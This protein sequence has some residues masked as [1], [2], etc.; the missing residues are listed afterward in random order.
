MS[1]EGSTP[2]RGPGGVRTRP[3]ALTLVIRLAFG[4]ALLLTALTYPV[5]RA[6]AVFGNGIIEPGELCD[7]GN[8]VSGDGCTS[9]G[10]IEGQCYDPG[11]TFSFFMFSDSY[12][13]AGS[14][15]LTRLLLDAVNRTRYPN[16]VIPRFWISTG[17]IPFMDTSQTRLDQLNNA[18]SDANYPF[19]CAAGSRRFPYFVALGNHDVDGYIHLT[20]QLQYDYW[21]NFLGPRLPTALLGVQN[22][23]WG[24]SVG[25]DARTTYSFDYKNAHFVV[26][27]QYSGD[28]AYPTPNPNA[29][30]RQEMMTWIDQDLAATDRP[31]KFVFGHEPAWSYCSNRPG[32]GGSQCPVGHPDNL[33]PPYRPRPYSTTGPWTQPY[34]RHWQD[35]L[36]SSV[37]PAGSRDEFWRMLGRHQVVAH[38]TGHVHT[39]SGRLVRADGTRRNEIHAFDKQNLSFTTADGIWEIST[40]QTHTS[41]GTLYTLVTVQD[42]V[43]TF[44]SYDQIT[45]QTMEPFQ[46]IERWSVTVGSPPEVAITSPTTGTTLVSPSSVSIAAEASDADGTVTEVTFRANGQTIGTDSAPP[47][48]IEWQNPALGTYALT[49]VATDNTGV[50]TTSPAVTLNI[51][52]GNNAPT[53]Q[54]IPPQS[55]PEDSPFTLTASASDVDPGDTLTYSLIDGPPGATVNASSGEFNWTPSEADGPGV[56]AVRIGVVDSAMASAETEI[57][58]TVTEVNT[59]P[60]IAPIAAQ[61]VNTGTLLTVAASATD[62]D[63]PA[64]TLTYSLLEPVGGATIDANTGIFTWIPGPADVGDHQVTIRVSDGGGASAETTFDVTVTESNSPPSL[65]TVPP[66]SVAEGTLLSLTVSAT[67]PDLPEDTLT[68]NLVSA[69]PGAAIVPAS[70]VFS[71][72][73]G[74]SDGPGSHPVTVRVTDAGGATAETTFTITVTETNVAPVVEAIGPVTVSEGTLFSHTV[75][76]T[77]ADLPAQALT[78]SIVTAPAGSILVETTGVFSWTP[79]E[80]D[81]PGTHPVT[82]RVTDTAGASADVGFSITVTEANDPPTLGPIEPQSVNEGTPLTLTASATDSDVPA[83]TLTYSLVTAPMGA[84]IGATTGVF[85]WTPGEADGPDTH[86][87]TIR[88]TDSGGATADTSFTIT[89]TES[90]SP[91]SLAA[92]GAQT[93]SEGT[94]LTVTASATDPDLP[95][96]TLTYSLVTAPAGAAIGASTGVFTWTP[97][98]ADAPGTHGVTIR[99]TDGSGATA[100]TSFTITATET[101]TAPVLASIGNQPASEGAL[102]TVTASATDADSPAQT[103]TYSIVSGPMGASIAAD[104]GVFSWTPDEDDGPAAHQVT[105]RVSDGAGGTDE[106]TFTIDVSEGNTAPVLAAIGNQSVAEGT[107]LTVT[108]SATD[109]DQPPQALTYSIAAAPMGATINA[110]TGAFSWTPGEADGPGAHPVTIRVTDS[111]GASAETS[112]TVTVT[113]VNVAPVLTSIGNQSVNEGTALNLTASATDADVPA[114]TLTYSL[115]TAPLGATINATTG[116]F[117]WTPDE[118]DGGPHPVTIRV[119]DTAGASAE[120]SFTITVTEGNTPPVLGPIAN[121]SAAEGT[122]VS[123]NASATDADV[124]AQTLTYSL[125]TAPMGATIVATTGAF[126]WTPGEADGPGTHPVT[127]RVTDSGGAADETSFTI[128]VSEVNTAP[129]L[130]P[131]GNQSVAEGAPLNVAAGATDADLPAQTLTY[132]LVTAPMGATIVATTGAFAWTPGEDDGPGTHPVTIRVTDGAGGT[133]ETSFTITVSEGNIPPVLAAIP[134]QSVAEGTPVN[135]TASATDADEPAQTLSYSLVTAPMGATINATT[136]AFSWTPGEADGPDAHPVTIR[137]TDSGGASAETSFTITVTEANTAPVLAPIANQSVNEGAAVSLS[138]SATDADEPAQTLTYSLVTAPMGATIG[139]TTGAF[140]WTPGEANGPGTHPV[141]VR[142]IDSDGG[143]AETSFTITVAE[144]NVA[145]VLTPIGNQSVNEGTA[146]NL[147]ASAT[148]ADVPAQTLTYSLVT[149][150]LGAAIGATT[151]AFSWTPDEDDGGPHPVTIRVTD[152]AG[153]SAETSFTI[154]VTEGNSPPVL[155]TIANQ[156]AAEGTPVNVTAS[157][158]DTDLPAQTLTYSLVTAPMGATIAA[159]TGVFSWTPGETDGPGSHPVT[160]RVTDSGGASAETSFTINVSEVNVAPALA[161][162][163]NQSAAEG[164][165]VNVNASATDADLPAQTLTYSLVTAPMG[166]TIGATTGVFSWTPGEDDEGPHPVTIR[167]T[168]SAGAAAET[169]FTITVTEGNSAPVPAPIANQSAAEG[170]PVN[171]TASATDADVPAQTLTFSLVTAPMGATIGATT[172]AFSWTPGEADG[173]GTHPVTIRVTDSGGASADVS[174]TITV[175]EVNAPPALAP[176]GDVSGA[177]GTPITTTA[178]ATDTDLP[179][180][181]LTYSLVSAPAGATIGATTGAFSWTPAESAGPGTYPVTVRVADSS[182]ATSDRS[183]TVTVTETNSAPVLAAITNRAVSAGTALTLTASATDPDVPANTLTFSLDSAPTGATI[184][185]ATGAFSWTPTTAQGGVH[186]VTVRVT[187]NGSPSLSATTSFTVTVNTGNMPDLIMSALSTTATNVRPGTTMSTSS[188]VRNSGTATAPS[189]VVR[190]SLSL[191]Q[192]YGGADDVALTPTRSVSNLSVNRTSTATLTLTVPVSATPGNYYFCAT[193]DGNSTV[194]ELNEGNN[195]LCTAQTLRVDW[196]DLTLTVVTPTAA[197]VPQSSKLAVQNT[198]ANIGPVPSPSSSVAFR[199]SVN[200]VVGDSDD[201]L[202]AGSR[203][204]SPINAGGSSATTTS[205]HVASTVPVGTYYVC[206]S[207]DDAGTVAEQN[208]ANNWRCSTTTVQVTD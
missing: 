185:P 108:A 65:V 84:T 39:Y 112:F 121:Q 207:V 153:A 140:S 35:S 44:E 131:I 58:I 105:I 139:A 176:L 47:Y 149:A 23:K 172:G 24:P 27:N 57:T 99:V 169:S 1:R 157:A 83:Q 137:V 78:F 200:N 187:D 3:T 49:A 15:G 130:A 19:N 166:A 66:Q 4:A 151:G 69:P 91:P 104:T 98:E 138:A 10:Q 160:V 68:Y 190:F 32:Y 203:S 37:C 147:T 128:T 146:L 116:A 55:I 196:P 126:S 97:G 60:T 46:L 142:V 5:T 93:A 123:V 28:P 20:P 36:N 34:G 9:T 110:T 162:I 61:S 170:S 124:P 193:A 155:A 70:G 56:Y 163:G 158:T 79:D 183:F 197:T 11:N 175:S 12:T 64:N 189:S 51:V 85:S 144:V 90:N 191:D 21:N 80:Q 18:I 167:V 113:E 145:P 63:L 88:V 107:A 42:N 127:I 117:S 81:G 111:G 152:T 198:V 186:T 50:T 7:D 136:G 206:A 178:S 13:S 150:P 92:I 201:I 118:D 31:I 71:W 53:F 182:G 2:G 14:S 82:I 192:N 195:G 74:E 168:D 143:T 100:E 135:V 67:D 164:S 52:S 184:Q 165:P 38:M 205:P 120:T 6:D 59:A 180:Q 134:N 48:Q 89:V 72:T 94:L 30:I 26:V 22:F 173:P 141:T 199:L 161:P 119:T 114:Q 101:N 87:V 29:C 208:E 62:A 106:T 41:S 194:N 75:E 95:G 156:S 8:L 96:E 133:A 115:V 102:F 103:L 25:P 148:D 159:T 43:V 54:P 86:P 122:P 188:T 129:V 174:F 45:G 73:P 154:T 179:A 40:G 33:D 16:R 202:L 109:A 171:V 204:V 17:D 132:S 76:A 125:V 77:D 177:E 181:A